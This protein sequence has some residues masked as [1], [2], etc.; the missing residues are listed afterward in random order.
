MEAEPSKR[1]V[2]VVEDD[3]QARFALERLLT[4]SG[5]QVYSAAGVGEAME[6]V[7][8]HGC[9]LLISD[10]QLPD[11]SGLDLMRRL[12]AAHGAAHGIALTGYTTPD[13]RQQCADAGFE[14]FLP[15]PVIFQSL[16]N[17]IQRVLAPDA[18]PR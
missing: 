15:K 17:E 14:A 11:G 8:A 2:V 12:R 6:I 7:R 3:P 18:G 13:H 4:M 16:L 1:C 10:L 9:D 5:F